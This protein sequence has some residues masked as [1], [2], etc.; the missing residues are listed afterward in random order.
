MPSTC[1]TDAI[2]TPGRLKDHIFNS[3]L[4]RRLQGVRFFILDEA[5]R[6]L[7][8]GFRPEIEKIIESLPN[9]MTLPRYIPQY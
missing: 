2:Q 8:A 1:L 9:R 4:D 6:L 5:D 7:D 3:G